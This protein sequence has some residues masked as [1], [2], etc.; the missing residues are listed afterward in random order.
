MDGCGQ[1]SSKLCVFGVVAH[2]GAPQP[3][4][5]ASPFGVFLGACDISAVQEGV[6]VPADGVFVE[7]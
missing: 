3:G 6:E 4:G 1:C 2:D 5:A 7:V